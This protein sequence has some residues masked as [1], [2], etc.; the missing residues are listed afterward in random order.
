MKRSF[1]QPVRNAGISEFTTS[2]YDFT[3]LYD[4]DLII[5]HILK[6]LFLKKGTYIWDP[7]YGT[8]F[9]DSLFAPL[10]E[11]TINALRTEIEDICHSVNGVL[12]VI[13]NIEED[14]YQKIVTL[15][16]VIVTSSGASTITFYANLTNN[17]ISYKIQ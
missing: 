11:D 15:N 8:D 7:E 4:D 2:Q 16:I 3:I 13:V 1:N 6:L 17:N 5:D 10:D 12:D 9:L 14:I